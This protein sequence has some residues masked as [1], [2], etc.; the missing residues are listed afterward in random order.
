MPHKTCQIPQFLCAL[1]LLVLV[2]CEADRPLL[3]N[4]RAP[5]FRLPTGQG[6]TLSSADYQ[7]KTLLVAFWATWCPPCVMEIPIFKAL[8][9]EFGTQGLQIIGINLD[10]DPAATLPTARMEYGFNYPILL[11]D[12]ATIQ[13]FGNF[14]SLPT[15]FLIDSHGKIR[16][17]FVGLH[18]QEELA[19][20]IKAVLEGNLR[21]ED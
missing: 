17:Q 6:D 9:Q 11:G 4:D 10:E 16:E 20:K 3:I 5:A 13:K 12:Q 21:I 18:P 19:A 8:Q 1:L 7:G 2:G 14:T 15:T